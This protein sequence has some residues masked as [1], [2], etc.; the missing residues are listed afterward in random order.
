MTDTAD[1]SG[2]Y[3]ETADAP[4]FVETADCAE[5]RNWTRHVD[6]EKKAAQ[7]EAAQSGA[8]IESAKD[9]IGVQGNVAANEAAGADLTRTNAEEIHHAKGADQAV[10]P[11]VRDA[12]LASLCRRASYRASKRCLRVT[13]SP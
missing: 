13:P 1:A 10:D 5:P 3:R 7:V 2:I 9:A 12:G 8:T 4:R 11:A 6:A